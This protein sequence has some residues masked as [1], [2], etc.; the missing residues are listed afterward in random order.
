MR[1]G[2][3]DVEDD[4]LAALKGEELDGGGAY[5]FGTTC[6]EDGFVAEGGVGGVLGGHFGSFGK[7]VVYVKTVGK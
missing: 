5:A 7:G 2:R 4:D 3:G 6:Y 1:A